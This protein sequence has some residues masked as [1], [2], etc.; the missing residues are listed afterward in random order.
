M[1]KIINR[2]VPSYLSDLLP[3]TVGQGVH[4]ALRNNNNLKQFTCR[5][6]K[7]KKSF[8]PDCITQWNNLD[9]ETRNIQELNMFRSKISKQTK[10]NPM[11]YFGD[12]ET[13][14]IHA[15]LRM[16]CSNLN[17]H[18]YQLHVIDDPSC[19]CS[20]NMEDTN[21]FFLDCPMYYIQRLKLTNVINGISTFSLNVLLY[22]DDN[23]DIEENVIIFSAVHEF[24]KCSGRL[25]LFN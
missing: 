3:Q 10:C 15:Q 2:S 17:Y 23:L 21:H 12:R 18:L 13:N 25:S 1:H 19:V 14:I 22:G 20:H 24:I 7:F 8:L 4:Y 5:T 6:E 11:Y 16:K 9:I